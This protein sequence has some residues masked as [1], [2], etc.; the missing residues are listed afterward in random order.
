MAL[1]VSRRLHAREPRPPR[2]AFEMVVPEHHAAAR[3]KRGQHL[4]QHCI[5]ARIGQQ[6]NAGRG[7]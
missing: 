5:V 7:E 6:P 4:L 1:R 3:R 2:V